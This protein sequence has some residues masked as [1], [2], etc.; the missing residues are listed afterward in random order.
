MMNTTKPRQRV[1]RLYTSVMNGGLMPQKKKSK[2]RAFSFGD[3]EPVLGN[4]IGDY[5][6]VFAD[7]NG[8][9]YLPPVS[10]AGLAKT[11]YANGTHASVL[12][13][14]QNQLL[15]SV[16]DNPMI[17]RAEF[18]GAFKDFEVFD[19][20]YFLAI[21]NWL[22]GINRYVR[23]PA[24]NVRVGTDDNYFLLQSDGS[25]LEYPASDII[26]L[27][28]GDIRQAIYGVP[29]YFAGI[30]SILL[31]EAAT[32][33]RRKYYLNGAHSGYILVTFDLD[34]DKAD[35]IEQAIV[36]SKGPGNHRSL[37]LNM[38]STISGKP[39]Y[40]KDRVQLL[41]VGDFGNRDEYDKIKEVTQQDILN[42]HRVP[43]GLASIMANNAAGHGDLKNVREVYYDCETIPKQA[44]W[45]ELNERLLTR[46]RVVFKEPR[47]LHIKEI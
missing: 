37:F 30:H 28:G 44:I 7:M 12:E 15:A 10:L 18:R 22:G 31:G 3:P 35:D 45:Q 36:Q 6:G 33:F 40:T 42:M 27:N 47:W 43:A 2:T 24:I 9:W 4:Q 29:T 16:Q 38:E 39:G 34:D 13:F 32:L 5:L 8:Y 20:A 23:L 21:R 46:G 25:F 11:L 17:T 26:H 41:P 14:K 1:D 19:N